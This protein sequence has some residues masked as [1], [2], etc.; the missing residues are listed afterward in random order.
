[1]SYERASW[2]NCGGFRRPAAFRAE[3]GYTICTMMCLGATPAAAVRARG[4]EKYR[5]TGWVDYGG[6][7]ARRAGEPNYDN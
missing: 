6:V 7:E 1:M 4:L 5:R 3:P 2:V